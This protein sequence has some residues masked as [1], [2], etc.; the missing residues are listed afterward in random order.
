MATGTQRYQ[1]IRT[2]LLPWLLVAFPLSALAGPPY[3]TDDPEPVDLHHWELYL[4]SNG[5][6]QNGNATGFG[7]SIEGNYGALPDLQLHLIVNAAYRSPGIGSGFGVGDT[8]FGFKYRF[9]D[10]APHGWWPEVGIFPLYEAPTG[11]AGRGLGA[12]RPQYFLPIWLQKDFGNWTIYGGGGYW[13]TP[14]PGNRNY[15]F[16]GVL[17]QDQVTH[18]LALGSEIFHTTAAQ[19]GRSGITG[20]NVGLQ[21]DVSGH[22]HLLASVGRGGQIDAVDAA[23]VSYP[24]V[25]YLGWQWTF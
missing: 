9:I 17:V 20:F 3:L 12:G 25:Y 22:A 11:N 15:W 23:L 10:P 7:P 4:F 6:I 14:G 2:G 19:I 1:A 8:E 18:S 5:A 13:I 24:Y 21:Y 16:N